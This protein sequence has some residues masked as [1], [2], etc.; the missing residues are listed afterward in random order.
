MT[1]PHT[2][3]Q[4]HVRSPSSADF[5][6]TSYGLIEPRSPLVT[7]VEEVV[8]IMEGSLDHLLRYLLEEIAL[9]GDQGTSVLLI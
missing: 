8:Q 4:F 2:R 3:N 9:C 7:A 5:T 6:L 1:Q